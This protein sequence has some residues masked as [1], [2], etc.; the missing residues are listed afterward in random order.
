[1]KVS[2]IDWSTWEPQQRATLLFVIRDG[3]I[4]LIHKKRG[5][6]AGMI[7]GPGGRLDPGETPREAAIREVQEEIGV[8]PINI[9]PC[10]ELSFQFV[11]GLSIFVSVFKASDYTGTLI[12]TNEALAEWFTLDAIPYERMWRDDVY[13]IPL[14]LKGTLFKGYFTFDGATLL[15]HHIR[16][17]Q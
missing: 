1:M 6:G 5:L 4:L 14:M 8:T 2:N 15:D 7:N 17:A 10:G 16:C 12:E 3:R 9:E 13:W 11:D